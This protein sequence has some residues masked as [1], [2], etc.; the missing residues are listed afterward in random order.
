MLFI[1]E[2]TCHVTEVLFEDMRGELKNW[3]FSGTFEYVKNGR[4][5]SFNTEGKE[6]QYYL[7]NDPKVSPN[8][9]IVIQNTSRFIFSW[10]MNL[11]RLL[12]PFLLKAFGPMIAFVEI[13]WISFL[14]PPEMVP[15][16]VGLLVTI[17]LVCV[18]FYLY[19]LETSPSITDITPLHI[20]FEICCTMVFNAFVEYAIILYTMRFGKGN[21]YINNKVVDMRSSVV[22]TAS[23]LSNTKRNASDDSSPEQVTK[24]GEILRNSGDEQKLQFHKEAL[25]IDAFALKIFPISFVGVSLV[26]W[27]Y[28]TKFGMILDTT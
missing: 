1:V 7:I 12:F 13:S 23:E 20:F 9:T 14:I 27:L 5:V 10:N 18:N 21:P 28:F 3:S 11:K 15:G 24:M 2:Q 17:L 6:L 22:Q 8:N 19:A 26:Y 16:R 25:A 4:H